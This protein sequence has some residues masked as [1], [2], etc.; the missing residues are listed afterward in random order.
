MRPVA[1][2][3][4]WTDGRS[5]H[6]YFFLGLIEAV[7]AMALAFHFG[8]E[9]NG[10]PFSALWLSFGNIDADPDL[11]SAATDRAQSICACGS[12]ARIV[13]TSAQTSARSS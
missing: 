3:D 12:R 7:S 1:R 6:A 13:L 11:L 9:R 8:F 2:A 10:I 5:F 4:R